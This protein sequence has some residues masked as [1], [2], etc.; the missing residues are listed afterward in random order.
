MSLKRCTIPYDDLRAAP[1][2]LPWG[3]S[4]YANVVATNIMGDSLTSPAGNG[5][6]ITRVPDPP[7]NVVK[8]TLV[9]NAVTIGIIWDN[10]VE[11]GGEPVL[12]YR[13]WYDQ[14][15]GEWM[16]LDYEILNS[17]YETDV[18]LTAGTHYAFRVQSRNIIGFSDYSDPISIFAAQMPDETDPPVTTI[19]GDFV[20]I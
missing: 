3:S 18:P 20:K 5:A 7:A 12:D 16:I 10:G 13:V 1:F 11:S 8:N 4:V 15:T 6:M 2:E 14:G 9:S 19:E 17:Q